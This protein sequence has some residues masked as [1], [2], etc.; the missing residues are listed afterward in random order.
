MSSADKVKLRLHYNGQ[1]QRVSGGGGAHP[2]CVRASGLGRRQA[3]ASARG[4]ATA[5]M[6]ERAC[7]L[8]LLWEGLRASLTAWCGRAAGPAGG[9]SFPRTFPLAPVFFLCHHLLSLPQDGA[10]ASWRY[11]GGEVYNESIDR[12]FKYADVCKRLNDKFGDT[13]SFRYLGPGD[14]AAPD[15]L[16][17][18]SGD[19]DLEVRSSAAHPATP[20]IPAW[21]LGLWARGWQEAR[22]AHQQAVAVAS[23]ALPTPKRA[24]CA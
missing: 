7:C 14:D 3:V 24:L 1:W 4:A 21:A 6:P 9:G 12:S 10:T 11:V 5:G 20:A 16:I 22:W 18:V 2:R 17:T 15:N 13:V 23:S 19:D 8:G